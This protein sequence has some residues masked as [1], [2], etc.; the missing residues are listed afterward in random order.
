MKLPLFS[1]RYV[2]PWKWRPLMNRVV[3]TSIHL[4]IGVCCIAGGFFAYA[5]LAVPDV[6]ALREVNPETTAFIEYRREQA[7]ESGREF[8]LRQTWTPIAEIPLLVKRTIIVSE[9]AAFWVHEGVDWHE[10]EIAL[11]Q[12]LEENR[13]VRGASTI[14]QQ[15]AKNLY[16]SPERSY[17]RKLREFFIAQELETTLSKTRI[18]EIYLNS[19]ELGDGIFGLGAACRHFF[20]K[21]PAQLSVFEIARLAAIIPRPLRLSPLKASR[22]LRNRTQIVLQ[23]LHKYKFISAEEYRQATAE[24]GR[25]FDGG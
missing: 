4:L 9:D 16:L 8:V 12:N 10:M 17:F 25:F 14:T 15:T 5:V 3:R 6:D 1:N 22:E 20:N 21:T 7:R 23:R 18:L 2:L 11:R 24:F 19:I 13:V